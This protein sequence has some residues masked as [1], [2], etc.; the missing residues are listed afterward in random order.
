M[1]NKFGK[2]IGDLMLMVIE[3]DNDSTEF[4]LAISE[5]K[6]LSSDIKGIRRL[7]VLNKICSII[8]HPE[9]QHTAHTPAQASTSKPSITTNTSTKKNA[10]SNQHLARMMALRGRLTQQNHMI[11]SPKTTDQTTLDSARFSIA[12]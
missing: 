3:N 5:L 12:T 10:L 9:Q 8:Q 6:K 4:Q 7:Q 2:Y 11:T 1:K